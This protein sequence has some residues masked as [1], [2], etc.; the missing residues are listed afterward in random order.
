MA[1]KRQYFKYHQ[2]VISQFNKTEKKIA[3]A[4][5]LNPDLAVQ[6]P[7]AEIAAHLEV[8]KRPLCVLPYLGF[9]KASV[10]LN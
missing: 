7:L 2:L 4:I 9:L 5:L 1:R 10:I 6:A 3:D 8:G